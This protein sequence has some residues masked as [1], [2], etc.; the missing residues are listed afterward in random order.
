MNEK[1]KKMKKKIIIILMIICVIGG[2][3]YYDS[4]PLNNDSAS[5]FYGTVDI[6]YVDLAF[7]QPGRLEELLV[8]EGDCVKK[9]ELLATLDAKLFKNAVNVAMAN[10]NYSKAQLANTLSGSRDQEIE[11]AYQDSKRL[12]AKVVLTKINLKR[13]TKLYKDGAV[14]KVKL[15]DAVAAYKERKAAFAAAKQHYLLLEEGADKDDLAIAHAKVD[16]L[17]A[18][19][20]SSQIILNETKLYAPIDAIVQSRILEPGAMVGVDTPVLTLSVRSPMYIRAYVDE[21]NLGNI[22]MGQ[23]VR[24][25]SDTSSKVNKGHV[26]FI[27]RTSEFTPKS[28]E[29]SE[30]RSDLMY[31]VRIIVDDESNGLNQGQPVTIKLEPVSFAKKNK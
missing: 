27:S 29:S 25:Y 26:G 18:Q 11:G 21:P 16:I 10:L 3:V 23:K 22:A 14:S 15:D 2:Y 24:I 31:R 5:T 1:I 19:L 8:E 12:E 13:Q 7:Q 28:V 30:L 17:K 4:Q 6:R 20:D 9:G